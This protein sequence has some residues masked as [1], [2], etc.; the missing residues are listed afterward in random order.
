[1]RL[2]R[3]R[4][5]GVLAVAGVIASGATAV[6]ATAKPAAPD[7][8]V[9]FGKALQ[10]TRAT[11]PPLFAQAKV[12]EADGSTAGGKPT[13]SATG[14]TRWRFVFENPGSK[15]ASATLS[16]ANRRFGKVVGIKSPFLEDVVIPKAPKMTLSTAVSKLRTAG[17]HASLNTVTL[18]RPL[19]RRKVNTLYLFGLSNGRYVSVDTVTGEVRKLAG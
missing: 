12:D 18:R 6:A 7:V 16:Y 11:R 15:F 19:G 3:V 9:L 14:I 5:I 10:Q 1:M 4:T 17:V 8:T 2:Q 13:S